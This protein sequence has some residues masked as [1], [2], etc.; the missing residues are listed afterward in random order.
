MYQALYRKWRPRTFDDVVGQEHI[1][2]TL[3]HQVQTGR[4]SHA[5]L[6]IGTRGTGK[7]TC[8]K[9]LARAVNCENPI[10]GNPCNECAAC[11]GIESGGILDVV[12][13]DAASNNRVD[14]VR[15]LQDEAIFSPASVKKRVYIIDE[16]H[17]L[18]TAAFNALLK[19]LEEPPEHLMF[20]LCTT[21]LHK[22]LPTI[23]SRCQRH[24]FKRIEP[25]AIAERLGYV[26]A[27]EGLD[28]TADAA[29]LLARLADGGMRD[30]LSLLDQCSGAEHID[31]EAVHSAMGLAGSRRIAEF[32][33]AIC[34]H[35]TS[36][37]LTLFDALWKD[38]KDPAGILDEL[39]DLMRDI[40]LLQMAPRGADALVSGVYEKSALERFAA[41][42]SAPALMDGMKAI[43]D[44]DLSG[45]NP[46]RAAEMCIVSLCEPD[47]GESLA[48]LRSRVARLEAAL[49]NGVSASVNTPAIAPA[50]KE[51]TPPPPPAEDIPWY[52]DDD[53]P[54]EESELWIEPGP[55]PMPPQEP[56]SA[57]E[58]EPV[59]EPAPP[60]PIPAQ[61]AGDD[62]VWETLVKRLS[63]KMDMGTYAMITTASQAA[64]TLSGDTMTVHLSSPIAKMMLNTPTN[65]AL[66]QTELAEI[67]GR[68]IR[69]VFADGEGGAPA[70]P[71]AGK[72]DA[73]G[74]FSNVKFE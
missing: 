13:L 55:A 2:A 66:F 6:F 22:V 54:P 56:E 41:K 10:N 72:L 34:A 15:A 73:L 49:K 27:Q 4:L 37:A 61:A 19:I 24:S 69:V 63:G 45:Q 43:R 52:T 46:R 74:R 21:E 17:M 16:V 33:D 40:L 50:E 51:Q 30:A 67:A 68:A 39:G 62:E 1:T 9:I 14:D 48:A 44:A 60:A 31:A 57:P 58:L 53:A 42:M 3:Q 29:G 5:Y 23:V 18:S 11:R 26:A 28:L 32:L 65:V 47:T 20:I 59:Y 71:D 38:G 8:A 7:T 35:E 12:E 64:G 36:Q 25:D 70:A